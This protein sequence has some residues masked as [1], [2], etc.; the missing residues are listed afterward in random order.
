MAHGIHK[1]SNVNGCPLS[2]AATISGSSALPPCQRIITDDLID[3]LHPSGEEGHE[4]LTGVPRG[5]LLPVVGNSALVAC[6]LRARVYVGREETRE[7]RS[8]C[9]TRRKP[10]SLLG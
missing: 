3:C 1:F 6:G 8:I 2:Q 4:T 5:S 7:G 9:V 10:S